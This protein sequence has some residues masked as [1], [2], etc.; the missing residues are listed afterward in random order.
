M[1]M[2]NLYLHKQLVE[3]ELAARRQHTAGQ[4]NRPSRQQR[5]RALHWLGRSLVVLGLRL[6]GED[7]RTAALVSYRVPPGFSQ[8]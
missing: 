8:N 2:L 3:Q 7:A 6:L 1:D 4:P 5:P